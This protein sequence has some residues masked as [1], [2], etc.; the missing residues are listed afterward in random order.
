M[1]RKNIP[2]ILMLTTGVITC[3]ITY[4][5]QYPLHTKLAVLLGVM[6]LFWLLGTILE[7]TLDFFDRQNEKKRQEEGEVIR[8][9]AESSAED[10][11][12]ETEENVAQR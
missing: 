7:K 12:N 4:I 2:I 9:D 5:R 11:T 3:I 1:N 10:E 8:K 6:V